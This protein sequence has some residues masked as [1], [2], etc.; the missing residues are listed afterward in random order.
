MGTV[1]VS[2]DAE[3][4]WGFHDQE[5]APTERIEAARPGWRTLLECLDAYDVPAT[6]G[7]VGHLFLEDC[8]GAHVGHPLAP[9]W[10]RCERERWVGRPDLR[11]ARDLVDATVAA[12]VDHEIGFQTFSHVELGDEAVTPELARAECAAFFDA[13]PGDLPAVRSVVF[14]RN[15]VGYRD[16]LAEWGLACYRGHP[17]EAALADRGR[18]LRERIASA[19]IPT[20]PVA[21]PSLDEFGLVNV[22]ASMHLADAGDAGSSLYER[23]IGDP[24][25]RAARRGIDRAAGDEGVFHAWLQP[26]DLV[27]ERDVE[28][29][30]EVLAYL[31]ERRGDGLRVATMG[32]VADAVRPTP[33]AETPNL[34]P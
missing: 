8:D 27:D 9:N 22:P 33:A 4:G 16:V 15:D 32:E 21:S 5:E 2:V 29:V 11:Y 19:A 23:A 7:V 24:V 30:R 28:R 3:L 14:P 17:P 25:V 10:F 12:D 6:W 34:T 13:V 31:D 26:G 18:T 1:V 20:P